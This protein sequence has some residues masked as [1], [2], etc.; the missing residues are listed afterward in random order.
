M[1]YRDSE[2]HCTYISILVKCNNLHILKRLEDSGSK[3]YHFILL[4]EKEILL[5]RL[6]KRGDLESSWPTN[7]ID[8]CIYAFGNLIDGIKIDTSNM[9]IDE[10]VKK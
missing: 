7:Q 1:K 8:R 5:D 2:K 9:N 4:A 10:I 3:I 6:N